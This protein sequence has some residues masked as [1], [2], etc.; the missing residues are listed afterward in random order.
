MSDDALDRDA[1]GQADLVRR[2]EVSPS[3]LVEAAIARIEARNPDL[4]AVIHER[5]DAAR[6]EAASELPDGPF[7]GVPFLVKDAVASMAGEPAH[8]GMA[9]L[10]RH[11]YRASHDQWLVERYRAA[12]F[13]ILGRTN[14][15]ELALQPT[16][17]PAATGPTRNPHDLERTPGG[18]SGG[19][20]AAVADGW[21]AAAHG[22]DM[23]GSIRI[24][25]S[26]CGL[27]GLKPSRARITIGPDFGE[28]WGQMTHEHVL[29]RS[30]R[31]TAAILDATAGP[32]P[33][34]PYTAPPPS[35][36]WADE[37]GTNPGPLRVGVLT[38]SPLAAV[39]NECVQA[40]Q[41]L[42]GNLGDAGHHVVDDAPEALADGAVALAYTT[43]LQVHVASE[44]ARI[45][46]L[47]G[48]DVTE[49][50]VERETWALA[51]AG[52]RVDAVAYWEAT[53][54][55]HA[56]SRRVAAWW[57]DH[58]LLITPTLA[59]TPPRLGE[60]D[61][62][63]MVSF[64]L[65]FNV[66]GQPAISLPVHSTANGLPVGAQLVGAAGREDQVIAAAAQVMA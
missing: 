6:D 14:L 65:P 11:G 2:G 45:G 46:R 25:A 17:E 37:V 26:C 44:L 20:A 18:S 56:W 27:V 40:A 36:P 9:F 55:M 64:T 54:A 13:V 34:D 15:P 5:F 52:R 47:V 16:T 7:R 48:E 8:A 63:A 12:G 33:G 22:N 43:M 1:V 31:D 51:E 62:M 28:Y 61:N 30:V 23:G 29:C 60:V 49:S 66:T 50:D 38:T 4:N 32:G 19:S 24:P 39:D 59:C 35:R 21:V 58:D 10:Q 42:A 53:Q 57:Q 3:E 41:I